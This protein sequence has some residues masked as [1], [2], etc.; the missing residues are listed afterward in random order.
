VKRV[1]LKN[2]DVE[3]IK[4]RSHYKYQLADTYSFQTEIYPAEDIVLDGKCLCGANRVFIILSATGFLTIYQGYSW[5]GCSGPTI[6]TPSNMRGSL[7]H[8]VLYQ[9]MRS[10]KLNREYRKYADLLFKN[11]CLDD[12]MDRIRAFYYHQAVRW[13]AAG[14]TK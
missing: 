12:G 4:L 3:Y 6:D 5:D 11:I 13:F 2:S 9:L 7:V 1:R 14:A 8:D 10:G